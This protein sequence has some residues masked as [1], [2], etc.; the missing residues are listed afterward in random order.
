M[1]TFAQKQNQPQQK[2]S[3]TLTR[4]K[5]LA[6]AASY[7]AQQ[8]LHLQHTIGNQAALRLLRG[9][10]D[11]VDAASDTE[12]GSTTEVRSETPT[13][14]RFA[15]DFSLIPVHAPAPIT[16]QPKLAVNTPG[17]IYEQEADHIAEQVMRM[18]EPKLQRACPCG[19]GCPT[20]QTEQP[21]H[22]IQHLQ[23]RHVGPSDAGQVAAPPIVHEVLA[24]PGQPLDASA[25]A[26]FE[27]RFGHDFSRVRVHSDP[28]AEQSVRHVNANAYTVGHNMVFGAGRFAPGTDEGRRLLAHELTHVVQQSKGSGHALHVQREAPSRAPGGAPPHQ[29][30]AQDTGAERAAAAAEAEAIGTRTDEQLDAEDV[31]RLDPR[32]R[33]DKNYAWS[34][35]QKD[36]AR[37]RKSIKLSPKL[38]QE[39]TIKIR[40]FEGEAKGAYIQVIKG[41]VAEV[42]EPDQVIE[43][44]A[45]P[46]T[47]GGEQNKQEPTCDISQKQFLLQYEEESEKTRCMDIMKDPEFKNNY[48]DAN[49]ASAV[50]YS[51][52]EDTT[53]ENVEYGRFNLMLLKYKN[54]SSEYF[55]LDDVGNFYYGGKTLTLL[56]FA[57]LKRKNGFVYPIYNGKIY[58]SEVLTPNILAQKNGLKYQI[59]DLQSLYTLLQI[60]G[61]FAGILGSYALVEGFKSSLEGFRKSKS[62]PPG[63]AK[64][65]ALKQPYVNN[66]PKASPEEIETGA[67]L[68]GEA[69]A[70]KLE[71]VSRVEGAAETKG[72]GRSGDYRLVKPDGTKTSADLA[73]PQ[74]T[75]TNSIVSNI[76]QKSGQTNAV[77][78]RLGKGT[79]GQ[80]SIDQAKA[81]AHDVLRTP[82][83]SI[84]RVLVIKDGVIIVDSAR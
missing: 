42:A 57:Y 82:G 8:I 79:S 52:V 48:F 41:A 45:G 55:M 18:P 69:Q 26:F 84:D 75:N 10:A 17:D 72:Q 59:K 56:E 7:E 14:T 30:A 61:A 23:T 34:L 37:I 39:I 49:I 32:K 81:I 74:S 15:Y 35:G 71:R 50:G 76:Y 16:I 80:L 20:C 29:P 24:S 67:F 11:R 5:R 4:S 36:K 44:L 38:Q 22:K 21:S 54:G 3:E 40:F 33:K 70:G 83:H 12:D 62:L 64:P 2:S 46:A 25:R 63:R 77:V 28:A 53:W 13:T 58:F 1:P 78:I 73:E 27:P 31:L 60:A 66:N 51:V 65:A 43:M 19:G 6:P 47:A 9:G 68:D